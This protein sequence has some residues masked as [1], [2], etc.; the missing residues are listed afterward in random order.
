MAQEAQGVESIGRPFMIAL[1]TQC[2]VTKVTG[3]DVSGPV[4]GEEKE[5]PC[6]VIKLLDQSNEA[7]L[8]IGNAPEYP[9]LKAQSADAILLLPITTK[10]RVNDRLEVAGVKLK[11]IGMSP[12]YDVVGKLA[13]YIVEATHWEGGL[14]G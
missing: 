7:A 14:T 5:E 6:A 1:R 9:T 4:F 8:E 10:A 11:V 13:H 3:T 12:S 2:S